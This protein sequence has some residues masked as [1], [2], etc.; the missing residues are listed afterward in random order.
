MKNE[1][2]CIYKRAADLRHFPEMLIEVADDIAVAAEMIKKTFSK[3]HKLFLFGNGGSAADAQH[4]AAEF[5]GS[6]NRAIALTADS[7]TVTAL[8]NDHGYDALFAR[9]LSALAE[10]GDLAIGTSTSGMSRNVIEGLSW[11]RTYHMGTIALIG[12]YK[13]MI[14]P[15]SDVV[16]A[17]PATDTQRIQEMHIVIGHLLWEVSQL[18]E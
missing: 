6:H 11:A 9:Q 15:Y 2:D 1:L 5:V 13:A 17:V 7:V 4:I 3:D 8:S 10:V 18:S 12:S 14:E 16:I